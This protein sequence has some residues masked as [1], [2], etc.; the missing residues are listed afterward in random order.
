MKFHH[1]YKGIKILSHEQLISTAIAFLCFM[2]AIIETAGTSHPIKTAI[3]TIVA[4]ALLLGVI[5]LFLQIIGMYK[6][7]K[8]EKLFLDSFYI[9]IIAFVTELIGTIAEKLLG[10]S[11]LEIFTLRTISDIT[12]VIVIC[13]TIQGLSRIALKLD[14]HSIISRGI[15]GSWTIP[16]LYILAIATEAVPIILIATN[17]MEIAAIDTLSIISAIMVVLIDLYYYL[18]LENALKMLEASNQSSTG[19][20]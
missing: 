6:A 15:S 17:T 4:V 16:T 20:E 8:D 2:E 12:S 10:V 1:A 18:Y 13:I 5:G 11:S 19:I 3:N 7:S 9:I 14:D